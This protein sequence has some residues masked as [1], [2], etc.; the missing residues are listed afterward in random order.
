MKER[1]ESSLYFTKNREEEGYNSHASSLPPA[2]PSSNTPSRNKFKSNWNIQKSGKKSLADFSN[3]RNVVSKSEYYIGVPKE[4]NSKFKIVR[5]LTNN[6]SNV[7]LTP[8][9]Y[10]QESTESSG[11]SSNRKIKSSA[12][13][14]SP[15]SYNIKS[16]VH[17]PIDLNEESQSE[18]KTPSKMPE[19]VI[20]KEKIKLKNKKLLSRG[21]DTKKRKVAASDKK[22]PVTLKYI[23]VLNIYSS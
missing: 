13:I 16:K 4:E 17:P 7:K 3:E 11:E 23:N 6:G 8:L 10:N 20:K 19:E 12:S 5:K 22:D 21:K 1:A 14:R 2:V 15:P 18:D 9:K